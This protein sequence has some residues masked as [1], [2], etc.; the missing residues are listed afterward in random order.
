MS[1]V[2]VYK[3]SAGTGKTFNLVKEY[4]KIALQEP[5][6]FEKILCITFTNKAAEEMKSR[7]IE[8]LHNISMDLLPQKIFAKQSKR[9]LR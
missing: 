8:D 3:A 9:K 5:Y 1:N 7:I 4:L 6:P 2:K